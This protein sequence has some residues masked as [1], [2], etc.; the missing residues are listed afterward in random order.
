MHNTTGRSLLGS[1]MLL[2]CMPAA[3]AFELTDGTEDWAVRF[4]N[5]LKASYGQ[6]V[7][8]QN[9]KIA[10]TANLNDGDKNFSVGS[11]VTQRV[12]LLTEL[13]VVYQGSMGFRV[14]GASW[15]D[16][17][18][19]HVGSSSNPFPG[20]AGNAGNLVAARPAAGGA[21][22]P[23]DSLNGHTARKHGLSN[24][25]DRYYNGPSGEIL[26]AFVFYSTEIGDE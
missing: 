2:A 5:T 8:K 17:A 13:D 3:Y 20:Q 18:Y 19:D 6:R 1:A 25:T 10:S 26:D 12:D 7:E 9:S 14:S 24:Y 21:I 11:A 4:D 15:Y 22:A 16:H 23:G